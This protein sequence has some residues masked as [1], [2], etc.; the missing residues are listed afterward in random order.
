MI[1]TCTCLSSNISLCPC[2]HAKHLSDRIKHFIVTAAHW[3]KKLTLTTSCKVTFWNLMSVSHCNG[4]SFQPSHNLQ[5]SSQPSEETHTNWLL[6]LTGTIKNLFLLLHFN[7]FVQPCS[8]TEIR[9]F[10]YCKHCC[11]LYDKLLLFFL[12]CKILCITVC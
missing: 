3:S 10:H 11:F 2:L 5:R 4:V 1:Q 8:N 6:L 7:A 9:Y 12:I